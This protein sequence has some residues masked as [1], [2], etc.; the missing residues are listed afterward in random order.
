MTPV[1]IV[2][3]MQSK[4]SKGWDLKLKMKNQMKKVLITSFNNSS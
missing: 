3:K 4:H 1:E 2:T